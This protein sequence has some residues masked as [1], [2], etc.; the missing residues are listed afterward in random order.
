MS[1][2]TKTKKEDENF[3]TNENSITPVRV[4]KFNLNDF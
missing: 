1:P 4:Q 2:L 3:D